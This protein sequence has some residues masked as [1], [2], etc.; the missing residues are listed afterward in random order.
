MSMSQVG[1]GLPRLLA[2][3]YELSER[4]AASGMTSIWRGHDRVLGRDVAVKVLHPELTADSTFRARFSE[5]AVNAARLTHPNV[6][7]LYDTGEQNGVAY[8]VSEW[9]EGANLADLLAKHGPMPPARAARLA[10]EVAAA[11]DYAH[12]AGVLHRNLKLANILVTMDGTVK[13]GDFSIARAASGEDPERTGEIL[14]STQHLAPEL[15][16]GDEVDGRTDVYA[17][18]VC[19]FEM[20]TGRPPPVRG[21]AGLRSPRALRAGIPRDIDAVVARAM[22]PDPAERF[23][24]AGA[25]ASA[26]AGAAADDDTDPDPEEGAV[27]LLPPP[28][29]AP[30]RTAAMPLPVPVAPRRRP[31]WLGWALVLS[32]LAAVAVAV[33]LVLV[34]GIGAGG[35]AKQPSQ[36]SGTSAAPANRTPLKIVGATSFDPE[37][38][39]GGQGDLPGQE[40]EH[41]AGRAFDHNPDSAWET[42]GYRGRPDFGGL[43]RGLG[44]ALD[45]GSAEKARTLDLR[46]SNPGATVTIYGAGAGGSEAPTTLDGWHQLT[47]P[48]T[49]D[50]VAQTLTLN[51]PS[52]Y[53]F[54][55]VWFTR[56]PQDT[57]GKFRSGIAEAA[58]S[59]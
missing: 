36:S 57:D 39:T 22:A 35:G 3:R 4:L 17:L 6:V 58:L 46:L 7:A 25:M 1:S 55:L 12:E 21:G 11:L 32:G 34:Q 40:N 47:Q 8:I 33:A 10:T 48:K 2:E 49:V 52:P 31:G 51:A 29:Q 19:L 59:S 26:L 30:R 5:E 43:K 37:D 56:L 41:K 38:T 28:R 14:G 13:V 24:T 53:R 42:Q 15:V 54:Y 20:L 50:G 9:V 27:R 23:Q 16:D 45:L 18:G 44:L